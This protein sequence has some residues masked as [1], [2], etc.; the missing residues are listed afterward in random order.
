MEHLR[1]IDLPREV[2]ANKIIRIRRS[3]F[4][5]QA[6]SLIVAQETD[7]WIDDPDW[8]SIK[9]PMKK[10]ASEIIYCRERIDECIRYLASLDA[11]LDKTI[12]LWGVPCSEVIY[13]D[14]CDV[15]EE[16]M[17]DVLRFLGVAPVKEIAPVNIRQQRNDVK[18]EWLRRYR[19][20]S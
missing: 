1:L 13:E 16:R 3:D 14:L 5:K 10:D 12:P 7:Q 6:I 17:S 20:E 4:A 2:F 8:G 19:S 9:K 18:D 15:F 11:F